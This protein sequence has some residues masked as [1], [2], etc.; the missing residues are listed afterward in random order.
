VRLFAIDAVPQDVQLP[1]E[2]IDE[3]VEVGLRY[4]RRHGDHHRYSLL[5]LAVLLAVQE[6]QRAITELFRKLGWSDL[7]EVRLLEIGCG[8][9]RNLVE[10]LRLGLAPEHLVGIELLAASADEA[11]RILPSSV[12]IIT[13]NAAGVGDSLVPVGTHDV[14]YQATVFSSLLNDNFQEQLAAAMWRWVRPGGG[15]LWYDFTYNNP[16]NPDVRG[17]SI[18]RI[19]ELFPAGNMVVR[20]LTLA[21]PIA[22]AVTRF[23]PALYGALNWRCFR[24]HLL[25]WLGKPK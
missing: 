21:P 14:V 5:N 1:Q 25:V 4:S 16:R 6:R 7:S 22:R 10:F 3:C 13:G 11:R 17:V 20:R 18:S 9:G 8:T 19:R 15:I 2:T 23:H 12:R 24:T